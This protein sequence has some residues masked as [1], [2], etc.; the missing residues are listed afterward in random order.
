MK[1]ESRQKFPTWVLFL[2]GSSFT[3]A[4]VIILA[5]GHGPILEYFQDGPNA[6]KGAEVLT[7]LGFVVG[8][9]LLMYLLLFR[10]PLYVRIDFEG[11]HYKAFPY[12]RTLKTIKW[13]EIAEINT[14]TVEPLSEFGGWG[15][16]IVP[17]VKRGI[18]M[19]GGS[20]LRIVSSA[21][22]TPYFLTITDGAMAK[23]AIDQYYKPSE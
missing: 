3:F 16:R 1:F 6:E 20:A 5:V 7:S 14:V 19:R 8:V 9:F 10:Y 15:Y 23:K 4:V 12:V 21:H 17:K 11:V 2:L 13:R 22:K 18:I